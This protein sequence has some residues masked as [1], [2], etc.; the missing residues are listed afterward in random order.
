MNDRSRISS[1]N[2]GRLN[3]DKKWIDAVNKRIQELEEQVGIP[4]LKRLKRTVVYSWSDPD[5]DADE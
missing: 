5:P 3:A 2:E 4:E 1:F